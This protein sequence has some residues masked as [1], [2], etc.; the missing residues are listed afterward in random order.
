MNWM[1]DIINKIVLSNAEQNQNVR[2]LNKLFSRE[3]LFD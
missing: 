2:C 3:A 1:V